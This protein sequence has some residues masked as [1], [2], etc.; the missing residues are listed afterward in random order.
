MSCPFHLLCRVPFIGSIHCHSVEPESKTVHHWIRLTGRETSDPQRRGSVGLTDSEAALLVIHHELYRRRSRTFHHAFKKLAK[1][2]VGR[3]ATKP[4][5]RVLNK[6]V[7]KLVS[8][9]VRR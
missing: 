4:E 5:T 6:R 8:H 9:T 7:V 2:L 1:L 3:K